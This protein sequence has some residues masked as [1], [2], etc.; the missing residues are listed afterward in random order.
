MGISGSNLSI[1]EKLIFLAGTI[2]A[3]VSFM[4]EQGS[5]CQPEIIE[6]L[7]KVS[8]DLLHCVSPKK[9]DGE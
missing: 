6:V 1:R 5:D 3:V 8:F 9:Q 4:L 2:D 7:S